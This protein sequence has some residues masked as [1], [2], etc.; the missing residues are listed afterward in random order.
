MDKIFYEDPRR[1][2]DCEFYR[3]FD[4]ENDRQ[5]VEIKQ[6]GEKDFKIATSQQIEYLKYRG[7]GGLVSR[8]EP[9]DE[10]KGD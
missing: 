10:T 4:L 5:R 3:V 1:V 7:F 6:G 9:P 8:H 2:A